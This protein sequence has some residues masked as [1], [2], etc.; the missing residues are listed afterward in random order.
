MTAANHTIPKIATDM[1]D[2][3]LVT[4]AIV[5]LRLRLRGESQSTSRHA[6]PTPVLATRRIPAL[7]SAGRLA[8]SM[9]GRTSNQVATVRVAAVVSVV[10]H[11]RYTANTANRESTNRPRFGHFSQK[12][13]NRIS[14]IR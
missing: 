12:S 10:N 2:T 5:Y 6:L 8:A 9:F 11:E 1:A 13:I 3:G 7:S 14:A 4:R